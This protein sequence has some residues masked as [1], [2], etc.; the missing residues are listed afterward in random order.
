MARNDPKVHG[1]YPVIGFLIV[2]NFFGALGAFIIGS[3]LID[4]SHAPNLA[5][6][7]LNAGTDYFPMPE[8]AMRDENSN[9]SLITNTFYV[10]GIL[11]IIG[12]IVSF[13]WNLIDMLLIIFC[14]H[15]FISR[16]YLDIVR[17]D[18]VGGIEPEEIQD[19]ENSP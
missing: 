7:F 15:C 5:R 18:L 13:T 16:N 4:A 12:G 2:V 19:T 9:L 10:V 17:D 3:W 11:A 14:P 6:T 1:L 8:D